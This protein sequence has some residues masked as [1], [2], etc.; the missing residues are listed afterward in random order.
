M[1]GPV[2]APVALGVVAPMMS[3]YEKADLL[4]ALT[5]RKL[6]VESQLKMV[7]VATLLRRVQ[8]LKREHARVVRLLARLEGKLS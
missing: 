2:G 4:N 5:R 8:A 7:D 1:L 3:L 6:E